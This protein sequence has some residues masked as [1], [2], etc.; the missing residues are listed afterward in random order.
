MTI[1]TADDLEIARTAQELFLPT[2]CTISRRTLTAVGDGT[3]TESTATVA[4]V[5]RDAATGGRE[6]EIAA[7][8]T[9]QSTRTVTLPHDADVRAEDQIIIGARTLKVLAILSITG[10]VTALRV[11]CSEG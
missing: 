7:K 1:L 4:T 5:C 6:L 11:L 9:A 8:L 2:A 3:Y 10:W